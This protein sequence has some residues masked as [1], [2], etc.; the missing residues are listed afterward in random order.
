[1]SAIVVIVEDD[2]SFQKGIQRLLKASG[3]ATE[4]YGSAEEFLGRLPSVEP[5]CI[6]IDINLPGI[7]GVELRRRL[8]RSGSKTP[9]IFMTAID[10]PDTEKQ[11]LMTGCLAYLHKPFPASALIEAIN[12]A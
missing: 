9:V 6:L 3:F 11:A 4:I 2:L 5:K 8:T 7:S 1:M 12:R 10:D